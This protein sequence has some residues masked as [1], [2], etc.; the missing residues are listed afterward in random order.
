MES[1]EKEYEV[2]AIRLEIGHETAARGPRTAAHDFGRTPW[3]REKAH[4]AG[5]DTWQSSQERFADQD[6]MARRP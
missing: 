4:P 1:R 2:A 5:D 6:G 3:D